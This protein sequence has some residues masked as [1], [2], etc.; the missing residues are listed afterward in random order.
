M[1]NLLLFSILEKHNNSLFPID[2]YT[3]KD[4]SETALNVGDKLK[5]SI[6]S[7]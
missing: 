7:I 5:S 1:C 6:L 2:L 3:L 4:N